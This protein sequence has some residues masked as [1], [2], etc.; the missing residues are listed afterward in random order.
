MFRSREVPEQ[1]RLFRVDF[2]F[3]LGAQ[4]LSHPRLLRVDF[5]F[6]LGAQ[7]LSHR[8]RA[9]PFAEMCE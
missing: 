5:G 7:P 8:M 9:S 3:C 6:C 2:G 1:A 4:P